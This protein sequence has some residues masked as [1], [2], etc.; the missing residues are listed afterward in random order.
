MSTETDIKAAVA[1]LLSPEQQAKVANALVP[2]RR[3][4]SWGRRSRATYF[5]LEYATQ[6][7]KVI[8]GMLED[9]KDRMFYYSAHSQYTPN[10]I[11][12]RINQSLRYLLEEMDV[13]QKYKKAM[14]I[15]DVKRDRIHKAIRFSIRNEFR[16]GESSFIP[17]EIVPSVDLPKWKQRI[18]EWLETSEVGQQFSLDRLA[19]SPDEVRDLK[20]QFIELTSIVSYI[21]STCIKLVKVKQ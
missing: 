1:S 5:N 21:T 6:V 7:K 9:R 8:D 13:D 18:E 2:G 15:I 11:Y 12:L 20:L 19:L 16:D 3:P 17:A 10:T 4:K 14:A